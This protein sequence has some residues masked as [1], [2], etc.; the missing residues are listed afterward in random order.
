MKAVMA[1]VKQSQESSF[2]LVAALG[3][4]LFSGSMG[5]YLVPIQIGALIDGLQLSESETGLLGAVEVASMSLTAIAISS[6]LATWSRSRTAIYGVLLAALCE[7]FTGFVNSVSLLFPLRVFVGCGFVFAAVCAAAAS[8]SEPDRNFGWAQAVMNVLFFIVFLIAPYSLA[9]GHHRGLFLTLAAIMLL[10]L[11][12]Y[13]FLINGNVKLEPQDTSASRAGKLLIETHILAT[14]LLNIGLGALWGFVER[15]GTH[16]I[17][18][19]PETIGTVL[20]MA[21]LFMIAG[22]LFAAW[23][24]VRIGRAIPMATATVL[25][26]VAAMLVTNADSLPIYAGGL[27]LYNAAYLFLGPYII[28]GTA[29]ALDPSGRLAAAMGGIMFFSY[30][31]GIGTGGFIA[32][33]ISLAGIG[34]L[35]LCTC[36]LAAPLFAIVSMRLDIQQ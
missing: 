22:S 14:V 27:F 9:F 6:R 32:E 35:A 23:L 13:R 17:G 7:F 4:G 1:E 24:G 11:P 10:T 29:A 33:L 5:V 31:V 12:L 15:I 34:I 19:S 2:W 8:T 20:S 25:C 26:A 28:A 36:L 3:V 21:T 18:L 30:S 16:N